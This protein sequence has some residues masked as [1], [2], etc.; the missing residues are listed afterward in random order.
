M[1]G[2]GALLCDF[3]GPLLTALLGVDLVMELGL[4]D[5]KDLSRDVFLLV[6]EALLCH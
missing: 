1:Q 2:I 4:D 6:Y 5:F 3:S